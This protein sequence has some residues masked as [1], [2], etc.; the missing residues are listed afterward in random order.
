MLI[1]GQLH[2]GVE[3]LF[4]LSLYS[5]QTTTPSD[6]GEFET[7]NQGVVVHLFG[8]TTARGDG[9]DGKNLSSMP[10]LYADYEWASGW[11][12]GGTFGGTYS[13]GR[14]RV[15]NDDAQL[16]P[17]EFPSQLALVGAIRAGKTLRV[18]RLWGLAPQVGPALA[19]ESRWGGAAA[20]S[21]L[22]IQLSAQVVCFVKPTTFS[23]LFIAPYGDITLY[24]SSREKLNVAG[25]PQTIL[26]GR[27]SFY[28]VGIAGGAGWEF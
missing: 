18:G 23:R 6:F 12:L 15:E 24:G 4:G 26:H 5:Q 8:A 14:R 2:V 10:R 21:M 20:A 3:R 1:R 11:T 25:V 28:G 17:F 13:T 19:F 22:M 27:T 9:R 7:L 16:D